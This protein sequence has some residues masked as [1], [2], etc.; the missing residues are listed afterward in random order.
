MVVIFFQYITE[1]KAQAI[2]VQPK[3]ESP[4]AGDQAGGLA[5]PPENGEGDGSVHEEETPEKQP[6]PE[7]IPKTKKKWM[8]FD[9]FCRCFK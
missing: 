9:Q 2:T 5:V 4:G 7:E 1:P 3:L 6:E 8:D